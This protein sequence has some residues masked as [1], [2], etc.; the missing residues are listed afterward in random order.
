MDSDRQP[1]GF[2]AR[3]YLQ[4]CR[5]AF[6]LLNDAPRGLEEL[7]TLKRQS[8]SAIGALEEICS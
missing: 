2:S 8:R 4:S 6:S 1:A 3:S 5:E 7:L